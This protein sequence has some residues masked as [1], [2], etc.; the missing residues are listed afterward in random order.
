M[1][2]IRQ[3]IMDIV[4]ARNKKALQKQIEAGVNYAT[5]FGMSAA[6]GNGGI[7]I[8]HRRNFYKYKFEEF[9]RV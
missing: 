9:E 8:S 2:C 7:S 6:S 4:L 3:N 1:P 5:E